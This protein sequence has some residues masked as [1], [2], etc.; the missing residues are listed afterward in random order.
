MAAA[1]FL[2][3][4]AG[5]ASWAKPFVQSIVVSPNPVIEGQAY[6]V[7]VTTSPDVTSAEATV[8]FAQSRLQQN[9][10]LTK[11]GPAWIG[12]SLV[13][14]DL[15]LRDFKKE[16]TVKIVV[17][18]SFGQR[19]QDALA[20]DVLAKTIGATFS[21][22]VLTVTGD[23]LDNVLSVSRDAI[24]NLLV[25]DGAVAITGGIPTTNNTTL[26]KMFGFKGNDK[27]TIQ[28]APGIP[29]ANLFGGEGNDT[30]TGGLAD[31]LLDGGPGDD[32]LSD[33]AGKNLLIGG[34]GNDTLTGG[35][36]PDQFFGGPDNDTIIWNP[37]DGSDVVEGDE[38]DDT[39][40][41][42]NSNAAEI[43]DLSANGSRLRLARNIGA[44]TMDCNAIEH[45]VVRT[46]GGADQFVVNDLTGL[47]IADVT[48]D[49]INQLGTGDQLADTVVVNGSTN[50]DHIIITGSINE[51]SV[52]GIG[53]TLI[54]VNPEVGLDAL[55]VNGGFGDDTLDASLVEAG[56]MDI[57][58]NG[59][60]GND[61]LIGG[62]GDDLLIGGRGADTAFGGPGNDV[63]QWNPGDGNDALEGGEGEDTMLFNGANIAEEI[64]ISADGTHV[65]F[66]RN[67]AAIAMDAHGVENIEFNAL[68]GG[69]LI[70]VNDLT[71]TGVAEVN[72]DLA[73]PLNSGLPDGFADALI[74]N[75]TTNADSVTIVPIASGVSVQGLAAKV[76][77]TGADP[78]L[79]TVSIN[80]L[81]GADAAEA[82]SVPAG[83]SNLIINGGPGD[84]ILVGSKGVDVLIGDEGDDILIGGPGADVLDGGPGANIIIQD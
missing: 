59:G 64:S 65:R 22:G 48:V 43:T 14:T 25:N 33:R 42:N 13:P 29:S 60:D 45:V 41:F 79:D 28:L 54:I 82:S 56:A 3:M 17:R 52:A 38:G 77:I 50:S 71:G 40:V 37:G 72:L 58:L 47:G 83:V 12:S 2:A 61:L 70:T 21:G 51:V 69:D 11:S 53:T 39:L 66:T 73:A 16:A 75:G 44:V 27:L 34:P 15:R 9:I 63:F 24:G 4:S 6:S 20:V 30:L 57:T 62:E 32:V 35:I 10:V 55:V 68:G 5:T 80:L 84:D 8:E 74:I 76:N 67:V 81:D 78:A 49:L 18:D 23:D 31:D 7:S 36:G 19:S 46:V 26:I 1:L